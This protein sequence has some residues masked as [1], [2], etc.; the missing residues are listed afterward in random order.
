MNGG[1]FLLVAGKTSA[2]A[3]VGGGAEL[4]FEGDARVEDIVIGHYNDGIL[5]FSR[6]LSAPA[7]VTV[8]HHLD[9]RGKLDGHFYDVFNGEDVWSSF[10][11]PGQPALAGMDEDEWTG[12]D[13]DVIPALAARRSVLRDTLPAPVRLPGD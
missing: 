11:D 7:V 4:V 1:P 2:F 5:V 6:N 8:D 13:R 9:I 12:L 3:V 10:L